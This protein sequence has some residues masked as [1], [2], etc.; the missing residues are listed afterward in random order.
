MPLTIDLVAA[1]AAYLLGSV[2]FGYLLMRVFR[3]E[4]IRQKGSG[5]IGATNVIRSGGKGLGAVTFLLD[6]LKGY[7]AVLLCE[8]IVVRMDVAP[9]VRLNAVAVAALAAIL[10]HIYTVW[11]GFKGGK[12]VATAF[13][14]FLALDPLAALAGL[15]VFVLVFALSRY[16]SLGSILSAIAFPL[17]ALFIPHGPRTPWYS[18][19]LVLVPL[20]VIA[21]HHQN[22]ARLLSGTE[23][24][25]GKTGGTPG[26]NPA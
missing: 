25:F 12:G 9:S 13:G 22:I 4:D 6:V 14:V 7:C 10:G 26:T 3:K 15:G 24:R 5:N 23:Y 1:I 20:I 16:V 19:V 11:L 17:F 21:K 8:L 18:A 2:P